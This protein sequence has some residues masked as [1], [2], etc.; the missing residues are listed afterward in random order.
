MKPA[1]SDDTSCQTRDH[2]FWVS[3]MDKTT[4]L[5]DKTTMSMKYLVFVHLQ[6]A[7][8]ALSLELIRGLR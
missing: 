2:T 4:I 6:D 1:I 7:E 3:M 5:M 8:T